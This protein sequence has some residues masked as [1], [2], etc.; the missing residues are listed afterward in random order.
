MKRGIKCENKTPPNSVTCR[1]QR[2]GEIVSDIKLTDKRILVLRM[3]SFRLSSVPR[4][5]GRD[6][7]QFTVTETLQET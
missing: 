7:P 4:K 3:T 6:G 5:R 1:V 2:G